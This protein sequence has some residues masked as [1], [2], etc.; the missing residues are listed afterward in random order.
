MIPERS[1]SAGPMIE[2]RGVTKRF[3]T[4]EVLRDVDL[5]VQ[6]GEKVVIIGASG[7][8][9]STLLRCINGLE[10]IQSGVIVVDGI[11]LGERG[12]DIRLVRQ[13][14]G[15][16]FQQFN[17]FPHMTALRNV[18]LALERVRGRSRKEAGAA[19]LE[20]LNRVGLA[21]K[22]QAHPAQLS[23]GQQQRVAIARALALRPR[24]ML[25][26][27]PTSALDPEL[28]NEVLDVIRD[29][30]KGGMTI[31]LVTHEMR[32]ARQIADRVVYLDEGR[33]VEEG[34]PEE[35]FD[36]P[37]QARTAAFLSKVL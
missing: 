19:A 34:T 32:F 8:G 4:H 3:G 22:T 26:D 7:S 17:L 9:K 36:R 1:G 33:I 25:F 11:R 27:E 20:Q 18:S 23:G 14:V 29:V 21:D 5:V 13:E 35:V 2:L 10:A 31:L 12:T 6:S 15:F 28:V 24:V 16:V 30:A 37:R